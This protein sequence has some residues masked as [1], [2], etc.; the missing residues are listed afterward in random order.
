MHLVPQPLSHLLARLCHERRQNGPIFDLPPHRLYRGS[1]V[2]LS[3]SLHG[4]RAA[5]PIGPAAGPHTQLAQNLVLSW[6]G[7]ARV[8]ELKTVQVNDT[9]HIPRPCI[10]V[11]NVG[12]NVEWSQELRLEESLTEYAK[13]WLLVHALQKLNPQRLRPDELDTLFDISVGYSLDGIKSPQVASWLD[14]MRDASPLLD[15]LRNEL[16]GELRAALPDEIPAELSGCVTLSTF[17]GCPPDEIERIVEH[18]FA[19]HQ[20]HVVVKL[21]PTLYGYEQVEDLLCHR[22]GYKDLRLSRHSFDSDL[23]WDDALAMIARLETAAARSGC[24]LGV[25]FSNTLVVKNH[26]QF[27]PQSEELMY[28]SGQPLH[29]L[30][31]SLA[32]RFAEA[33]G[34]RIPISFSGGIDQKNCSEVVACGLLP[35]TVCTD[36]LRPGGYGRMAKY[37]DAIPAKFAEAGATTLAELVEKNGGMAKCLTD[38]AAK[39][40]VDPR[41]AFAKNSG[42][43]R[44]VDSK[45]W[46]FD[47][48]SCDKCIAVCPND[49]NFAITTPEVEAFQLSDLVVGGDG[50]LTRE[51]AGTF[52]LREN[53]Q[54][55]NFA[56]ACNECG[57]CDIFCPE[58]GG[59]YKL[60]PR[61]FSSAV[62]YQAAHHQDGFVVT[63]GRMVGRID[64]VEHTLTVDEEG[65]RFGDGT[66][67][68]TIGSDGTFG[69]VEVAAGA[70]PGHRLKLWNYHA[71][72][73]LYDGLWKSSNFVSV[74]KLPVAASETA[75]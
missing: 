3:V 34:G 69:A 4:R 61:F 54:I 25:K 33:T 35:V 15:M 12:Y 37:L 30:A 72:R 27:F 64:G 39:V 58:W 31:I 21:N 7:G 75:G 62:S 29:V 48:L 50:R 45:L 17:H 74:V 55:A 8:M 36:L 10:D 6:L 24:R 60:K 32:A 14:M 67:S 57:N 16:P 38:Y 2:D 41:Y 23:T 43:P 11:E 42:T 63:P 70:V 71:M 73:T 19:R 26:K 5:S 56:D 13:G 20:M 68:V 59:P 49:A 53:V 65:T 40:V 46:L 66:I 44:R 1:A 9:L 28:L 22:L 51:P 52:A 18:L 47:C